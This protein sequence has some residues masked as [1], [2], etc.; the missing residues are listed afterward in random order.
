[1]PVAG[2]D[3]LQVN[4]VVKSEGSPLSMLAPGGFDSTIASWW[5]RG[6][7]EDLRPRDTLSTNLRMIASDRDGHEICVSGG[8]VEQLAWR[9]I[10][11]SVTAVENTRV[12]A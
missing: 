11:D 12:A 2:I 1:M 4:Y 9:W 5:T 8:R 3:G 7:W 10:L 6:V